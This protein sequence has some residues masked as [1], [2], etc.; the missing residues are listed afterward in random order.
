M[1]AV[2]DWPAERETRCAPRRGAAP[3]RAEERLAA[4]GAV[5]PDQ[6]RMAV[7]IRIRDLPNAASSTV[8]WSAVCEP[9]LPGRSSAARNSAVLSSNA[10]SG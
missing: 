4:L 2:G 1:F 8:M 7:P 9:A 5:G 6:D 3:T 10:S